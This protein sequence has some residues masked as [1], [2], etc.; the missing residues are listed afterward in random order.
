MSE[1]TTATPRSASYNFA[2]AAAEMAANTRCRNV[3]VLDLRGKSPVTEFFV[4][5]TGTSPTQMRTVV[6]E[7][8][9]LGKRRNFNAWKKNGYDSAKWIVLDFVQVV[10]HVFDAES[11]EFYDLELLWGDSPRIDW[12]A[13]LGLPPATDEEELESVDTGV[14]GD[15]DLLEDEDDG[16]S[17]V[18]VEVPDESTGSNSVAFLEA[19]SPDSKKGH[20]PT[21][22]PEEED[23]DAEAGLAPQENVQVKALADA[24]ADVEDAA[25]PVR[26]ARKAKAKPKAVAK[27]K[28]V[29]KKKPVAK[30]A[31][32]AG[33]A[34]KVAKKAKA[35]PKA[36]KPA[37]KVAAKKVAPKKAAPKKAVKK[38]PAKKKPAAKKSK[39]K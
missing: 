10:A 26:G 17:P 28:V 12:R 11:R 27:K 1:Q 20:F 30:K 6:D 37:V 3:V 5:A 22:L 33:K 4:I 39:K 14:E 36:K 7:M 25:K 31:V 24:V 21:E 18:M 29:A 38:A 15:A 23:A 32:K 34:K 16:D 19:E 2:L 13:E 8:A 35:A 9:D